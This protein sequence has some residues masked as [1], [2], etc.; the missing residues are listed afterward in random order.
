[1]GSS[2]LILIFR[3]LCLLSSSLCF[4][5]TPLALFLLF[6]DFFGRHFYVIGTR[7]REKGFFSLPKADTQFCDEMH[8]KTSW[9]MMMLHKSRELNFLW[10]KSSF[11]FKLWN[12]ILPDQPSDIT[13]TCEKLFN[14]ISTRYHRLRQKSIFSRFL[15]H[16]KK[17]VFQ[18]K[19]YIFWAG[20]NLF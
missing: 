4:S 13:Q 17:G 5:L 19:K 11:H 2:L 1:M 12:E 16:S 14:M 7:E 20:K 9:F 10:K 3:V 6:S 15:Q 18:G 8:S